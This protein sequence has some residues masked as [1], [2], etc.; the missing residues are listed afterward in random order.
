MLS[1][2]RFGSLRN[3]P[4]LNHILEAQFTSVPVISGSKGS[5]FPIFIIIPQAKEALCQ[6][7]TWRPEPRP[8]P[9]LHWSFSVTN[10]RPTNTRDKK[11]LKHIRKKKKLKLKHVSFM[12]IGKFLCLSFIFFAENFYD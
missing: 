1:R 12:Q 11:Y 5:S 8:R 10:K 7:T 4:Q 9:R 3:L 6:K 2:I